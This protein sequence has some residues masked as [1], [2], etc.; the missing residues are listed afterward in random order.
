VSESLFYLGILAVALAFCLPL[1]ALGMRDRRS[2]R[3]RVAELEARL[4]VNTILAS[5]ATLT[6]GARYAQDNPEQ[7]GYRAAYL[8]IGPRRPYPF[9]LTRP[10]HADLPEADL[11]AVAMVEAAD[12]FLRPLADEIVIETWPHRVPAA[13][14]LTKGDDS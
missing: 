4:A 3:R 13:W 10:E 5:S 7:G 1:A 6:A 2:R 9:I 12:L 8:P 14:D 11:K